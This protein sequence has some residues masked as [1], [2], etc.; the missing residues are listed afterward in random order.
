VTRRFDTFGTKE[1]FMETIPYRQIHMDFHTSPLIPAVGAEFRADEFARV[2]REARVQSINL[3]AKC[4]HGMYY[5]PTR[6]GTMHPSL[7]FDL[8]GAQVQAC[9]DAGIR[10]CIY[11]CVAWNED[12]ADRHPE[13]LQVS[14]EGLQGLKKPFAPGS[15]GWR[16]LCLHNPEHKAYLRAE[17]DETLTYRPAAYWID[18]ILQRGCVCGHCRADMRQLGLRPDVP[19]DV[20]RHDRIVE[21]RF[22]EEFREHIRSRDPGVGVYFNGHPAEL[23]LCDEPELSSAAKRRHFSFIDIESLPSD[24]WGYTH[25]PISVSFLGWRDQE[26]CMMNGKFHKSWG[27]FGSLRNLEAL[28]YECFRA[29]AHGARCCVGDQLHPSGRIDETV[30]RRIGEVYRSVEKKEPWLAGTTRVAEIGIFATSRV[31]EEGGQDVNASIEGAYRLF[32]ELHRTFDVIDYTADLSRY[33]LLVLPDSVPLSAEAAGRI[34]SSLAAGG[35]LLATGRSALAPEGDRFLLPELGVEYAGEA[36]HCPRYARIAPEAFPAIPP[37]DYVFYER[38]VKVR[39]LPGTEV[40]ASLVNPYFDRTWEHF[41][42][43]R[44][45]P[46]ASLTT[47]PFVTRAGAVVYAATPL[48]RDYA[49]NGNQV[50]KQ[51]AA[52]AL[53]LLSPEPLVRADLPALAEV[54]LRR[55]DGHLVLH[56]LSYVIQRKCRTMDIVEDRYPLVGKSF[57]V[58]VARKPVAVRLVPEGGDLP[59]AWNPPYAEFTV[60]RIEGHQMILIEGGTR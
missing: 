17:I 6:I 21:I 37:M 16:Y 49:L 26:L 7:R 58:K 52:R 48:F 32:T 41:S 36:E 5:Y 25:F 14:A 30:Y 9:R 57:A 46:P 24:A 42:S 59:F 38:G 53:E 20:K 50:Y 40:L 33:E 47:E 60:P 1:R 18:I 10:P 3:F 54:T 23:D 55:L 45:T 27:D 2:L 34:R 29:L 22:M 13:W 51:I 56:V 31:L 39:A 28:E 15:P 4:H 43:H 44:Q 11:T 35:R 8:L 12:W 19:S